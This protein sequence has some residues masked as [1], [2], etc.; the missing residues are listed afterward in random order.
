MPTLLN[1]FFLIL[2]FSMLSLLSCT[3]QNEEMSRQANQL[4]ENPEPRPQ[5]IVQI[6]FGEG[7]QCLDIFLGFFT[8]TEH[9][10][11]NI[12]LDDL[13]NKVRFTLDG[14]PAEVRG[15]GNNRNALH[16]CFNIENLKEGLHIASMTV[17]NF[18]GNEASYT[19]VF[20]ANEALQSLN[21]EALATAVTFPP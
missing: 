19:W 1:R 16:A 14:H 9:S 3:A 6:Y 20:R 11:P 7:S 15:L 2:L 17:T 21:E 10:P 4:W 18:S 8:D 12:S 5:Y 13:I